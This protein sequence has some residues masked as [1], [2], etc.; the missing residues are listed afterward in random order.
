M[1]N[2]KG[3]GIFHDLFIHAPNGKKDSV[4]VIPAAKDQL[5]NINNASRDDMLTTHRVSPQMMGIIPKN[6]GNFLVMLKKQQS[7]SFVMSWH[8][9]KMT[10]LKLFADS[11]YALKPRQIG[12]SQSLYYLKNPPYWRF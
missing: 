11:F 2:S 3:P 9:Y 8:R 7:F 1:K 10:S 5:L 4:Q 6:T 12:L